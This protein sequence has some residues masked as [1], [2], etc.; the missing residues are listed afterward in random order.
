MFL[1]LRVREFAP[2]RLQSSK[3]AL[4][5]GAHEPRIA[6]HIS[7]E[8]GGQPAFDASRGQGGAP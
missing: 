6:R 3:G 5:V 4:L 2:D 8:N 7:G 1:Y